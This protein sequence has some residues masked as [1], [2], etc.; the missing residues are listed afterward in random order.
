MG[1]LADPNSKTKP[2]TK[3]RQRG[4]H[5]ET[6][7][8]QHTMKILN[9]IE[10]SRI[11]LKHLALA[12]AAA[13]G[14]LT[15]SAQAA[16]T[17][18]ILNL[19]APGGGTDIG[20][21]AEVAWIAPGDL[22]AGSILRSVSINVVLENNIDG[23]TWASDLN[24]KIGDALLIGSDGGNPDWSNGQDSNNGTTCIDT[25]IAPDDFPAT[26]DLNATGASLHNNWGEAVWSGTATVEYDV[27]ELGTITAF[28]PGATIDQ[29]AKTIAWIVPYGTDV[30]TLAPTYT[31]T[32]GS[33][34]PASG[35]TQ[36]FTTP[37]TYTVTDGATVNAYTVTVIVANGLTVS[38]YLGIGYSPDGPPLLEPISNLMARTPTATGYQS[39]NIDYHG[40]SF[41]SLPGS[42]GP[43]NFSVLWDGWFDV[44]KDGWGDYTFGTSSDDGSVLLLDL[45]GDG[46]FT[47][48]GER[49]VNNN[50]Y[51]GNTQ[52]T[53]TVT[54]NMDSV[55]IVIG[56]YQGTGGYDMTA[57]FKKGTGIGWDSLNPI[58]G[59]DGYFF[60]TDP[61]P[62]G[63]QSR[64]VTFTFP[65]FG[66]ATI[67]QSAKT[68]T[69]HV[70]DGTPV[71]SLSPTF[72]MSEGATCDHVSG[73]AYD[74]TSPVDYVVTA[75]DSSN[76]TT[77]TVSVLFIPLETTV[78]WNIGSGTWD[79][80]TS[81]WLGQ[82]SGS[83]TVFTQGNNV[84]FNNSAGGTVT[85]TPDMAP[86]STT[87]SAASGTYTLG[88]GAI[89]GAGTLTKSGG[90]TLILSAANSFTG[91]TSVQAGTLQL[92][93]YS[94]TGIGLTN[95]G[96]AGPLGAPTGADATIDLSNGVTLQMGNTSPR[97]NQ[98]TDRTIN[99][100]S[101]GSGTVTIR[102]NDN[103]TSF[104]FGSV[105]ATG[106]GAKNLALFTGYQGNG[107]RESMIFN[108]SIADSSDNSPTSLQV[109]FRTQTGSQS[110]VS[111][112]AGG[113]FTGPITLTKGNADPCSYYMTIGGVRTK[114]GGTPGSGQ[115]GGGSYAGAISLDT[116]TILN[117]Y[118]SAAQTLSGVISGA[119][120]LAVSAAGSLTLT[121]P[122]TYGGTTAVTTGKLLVDGTN[123]G[124]GA[125][126]VSS[127]ATLGGIGTI[128][129]NVT[130]SS[131][132]LAQFTEGSP[133]TISG[134][135][136]LNDNVVHLV[137]P[138]DLGAAT[139]TLA[140][141]N[142]I[143][144]SGSFAATPVI[145]SGSLAAG[146]TATVDT[147]G[148]IVSLIVVGTGSA[149]DTW[150][151][152]H[153]GGQAANL[154]FNNDGVANGIA[155]FMGATG[156]ATNP[157][158]VAGQI[159]WPHSAAATGITYKVLTS[160]N[161]ADWS[162]VTADAIDAGGFLTYT[163]PTG[164]PQ[165]FV[166][167]EVLVP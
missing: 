100:A 152:S 78:I 40:G 60:V 39:T 154:D 127:G 124:A 36:N 42:P 86:A 118:S 52:A 93:I 157:G 59:I 104:T 125:A 143:G 74:F 146:A 13:A 76:S 126:S 61:H 130:Y 38:T 109:T 24:V 151:A 131:G 144:S 89:A 44:T 121:G 79:T 75:S 3:P 148:G 49:I 62:P 122:N 33:C 141:Y 137:L 64:I 27:P 163:L 23:G 149:Y 166:R 41:S 4:F 29:E 136:T 142:P 17:T 90:G 66:S 102:A 147:S 108:G 50:N 22:P 57:R 48:P 26:I 156:L 9:P 67:D 97:V 6:P 95:A 129:G 112:N 72:T 94:N 105:T 135:L 28:G 123:S 107:D 139:Y 65:T 18:S 11:T 82:I 117:Y 96:V 150:A 106:T 55:H 160:Q 111:L 87:V 161:L 20:G 12:L 155:Y 51:Q 16:T 99:L 81:N 162:D 37:Q 7:D 110:Y 47:S 128:G 58:N 84:I 88:S 14:F 25:K 116:D 132:A 31:I 73:T 30:T 145:D 56:Y 10:N 120:S 5:R 43:E 115:L 164:T 34:D 21:G 114:D 138:S 98:A 53:G 92:G 101:S 113:T 119:G 45:N 35:S 153:A 159:A 8:S 46:N 32:S 134:S 83:P 15:A 69:L 68:I 165:L 158:V 85:V 2:A 91:K 19:G 54:L 77:Y 71:T 63:P 70:P 167:L 140:T 80:S 133:L 103:D 1:A